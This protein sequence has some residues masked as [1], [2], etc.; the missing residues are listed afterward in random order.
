MLDRV[1]PGLRGVS[2]LLSDK[3]LH[4]RWQYEDA[5]DEWVRELVS[6]AETET[7]ADY[8]KTHEVACLAEHLPITRA[9][10]IN[11]QKGE[12]WVFLRYEP[13]HP[14]DGFEQGPEV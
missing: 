9:R 12:R 1:T 14:P 4:V 2:Y 11:W 8:W 5:P 7:I 13:A 3:T 10:D 6:E